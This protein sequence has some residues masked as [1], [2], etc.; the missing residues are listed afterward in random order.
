M[1]TAQGVDT[2]CLNCGS[3]LSGTYC[4]SCG[5]KRPRTDLTLRE[6]LDET[7]QE[8]THWEG[9][10]PQTLKAL[11]LKPGHLTLDFLA[12]RRARW[13][14]PLRVYLICSV[15]FFVLKP[16]AESVSGRYSR[17]AVRITF[18]GPGGTMTAA[19]RQAVEQGLPARI[20]GK[21]RVLRAPENPRA[22]NDAFNAGLP[23]AMFILLPLFALLTKVAWR[24]RMPRYP[25]HLYV[26]LHIHAAVFVAFAVSS[27][28][29]SFLPPR[30]AGALGTLLVVYML[31]Y[32][33]A[34]FKRVFAESWSRTIAKSAF[35]GV[36]YLTAI[37]ATTFG[38]LAWAIFAA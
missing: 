14:P 31:W 37:F 13:L 15:A 38:L 32:A 20:F 18:S 6:F 35:V 23:K 34:A 29:N 22:L 36:V 16:L 11:V 17:D 2:S 7:T 19:E 27:V 30:V 25:A 33:L 9:K 26:A 5:Q 4:A 1:D 10:V 8:L 21:E 28:V 24:K 12:G 3:P